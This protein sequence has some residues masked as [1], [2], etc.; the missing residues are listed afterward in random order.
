MLPRYHNQESFF[1]PP[2]NHIT[3]TCPHCMY[4]YSVKLAKGRVH[5]PT[6]GF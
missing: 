6:S 2:T 1:S 3:P 4:T 5:V